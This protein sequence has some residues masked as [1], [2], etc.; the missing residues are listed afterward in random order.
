MIKLSPRPKCP[1][2]L[3]SRQVRNARSAL[4]RKVTR[5]ARLSSADFIGKSYWGKTK[6]ALHR[7][8]NG[9]CC[10][11]ERQREAKLEADVEHFRPKLQVTE[12]PAH[13]GYW[14][15]AYEW[16]NLLF[17]CKACN[18]THKKNHF[19]MVRDDESC[20]A[21]TKD[22]DL[23][24]ERPALIDPSLEDPA[25]FIGYDWESDSSKVFPFGRDLDDRG[26]RTIRI[27]GLATRDD[28]HEEIGRAHV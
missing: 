23:S 5:G 18:S 3:K 9:K 12:N 28:L 14:W 11:C 7:Y 26:M 27:L 17:S 24:S 20:R 10:F 4:T 22:D 2:V 16:S 1:A 21:A 15:L 25:D 19:P 6:E 8:Q 13:S